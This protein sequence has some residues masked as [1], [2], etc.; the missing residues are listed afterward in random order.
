MVRVVAGEQAAVRGDDLH[1]AH[2]VAG[3]AELP[4]RVADAAAEREAGDADGRAR[5]TGDRHAVR[6]ELRVDV[7]QLRARSDDCGPAVGGE[8][9]RV[10]AAY[11]EHDAGRR[12]VAPVAVPA[13]ARN[14]V[15]AVL[16]GPAHGRD[17]VRRVRAVDDRT[18]VDRVEPRALEQSR[19]RVGGRSGRDD[20]ALDAPGELS[21]RRDAEC[22][23]TVARGE[24][25]ERGCREPGPP[26]APEER[27]PVH[28]STL[29]YQRFVGGSSTAEAPDPA[30][31]GRRGSRTPM[32]G[33]G[34]PQ[35]LRSSKRGPR[36]S[37][38]ATIRLKTLGRCR[39]QLHR[40]MSEG[41][42]VSMGPARHDLDTA[43]TR[44]IRSLRAAGAWLDRVGVAAVFPGADLVLPSLWEAVAGS[45]DVDW[46][47]RDECGRVSF[48]P[49]MARCWAWKDEL[50]AHRLACVGKHLGRWAALVSPRLVPQLYAL[51]GRTGVADDFRDAE[52]T[53]LQRE[54][55]EA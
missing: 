20:R 18:W 2:V 38:A 23:A 40:C 48:T 16:A 19:V 5:S 13:G 50:P 36:P 14:D 30:G 35:S 8:R 41:Y 29:G 22:R 54:V 39:R 33:G 17:D 31:R 6:V 24:G 37:S 49:E 32:S 21:Q 10:Q 55:A 42:A 51:T 34:S 4:R 46:A 9:D 45:R 28:V 43:T 7:D 47:V 52:L 12:R 1:T 53:T 3:E 44:R 26:G 15:D 25:A 11:V 27:A